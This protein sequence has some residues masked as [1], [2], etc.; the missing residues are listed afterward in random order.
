MIEEARTVDLTE[1]FNPEKDDVYIG[2]YDQATQTRLS[3]TDEDGVTITDRFLFAPPEQ[4]TT[5]CLREE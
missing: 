5:H 1:A 2:V 3:L 4:A